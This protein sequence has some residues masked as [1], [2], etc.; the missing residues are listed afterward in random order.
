MQ[1][2]TKG[3]V[4]ALSLVLVGWCCAARADT[5]SIYEIQSNTSD[6]DASTYDD[7]QIHDVLGGIVTHKWAG[8]QDRVYLQHPDYTDGWGGIVVKD[9]DGAV[10]N[11]VEIGDWVSFSNV[12]IQ[13]YRG[14]TFIQFDP[15]DLEG[16]GFSVA[17]SGNPVPGPTVVDAAD[18]I[19]PVDHVASEKYESM[20]VTLENATVGSDGLGKAD[21]PDNYELL[22]GTDI[23][24]GADYMNT[25][26]D[27]LYHP[28]IYPGAELDSITGL[29]EQYTKLSDGW[30]YYQLLTRSTAD[31]VPE[32]TT[33][34]LFLAGVALITRRRR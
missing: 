4:Y 16:D 31:I 13:E 14:T 24:W 21:P 33:A 28:W 25:D 7:G 26:R 27:D 15:A 11:G 22:Q 6:G 29:V 32:P 9:W 17:S 19:V 30:D 12:R 23:A 18:L 34:A 5:L 10:V 3:A 8:W 2:G 20:V 1:Q